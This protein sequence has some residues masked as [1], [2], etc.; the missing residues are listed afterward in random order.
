MNKQQMVYTIE[1]EFSDADADMALRLLS[2]RQE[3]SPALVARVR[4]IPS[5]RLAERWQVPGWPLAKST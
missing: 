3:P 5:P 1:E 4:A 2:L